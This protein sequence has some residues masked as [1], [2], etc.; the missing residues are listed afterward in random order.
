MLATEAFKGPDAEGICRTAE[1]ATS[2]DVYWAKTYPG[3]ADTVREVRHD[4]RAILGPCPE[5][6]PF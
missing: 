1:T 4:V 6:A 3:L 2:S 5:G